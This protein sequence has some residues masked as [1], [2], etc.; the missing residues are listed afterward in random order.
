[1]TPL[2]QNKAVEAGWPEEVAARLSAVKSP[3]GIG[4][5]FD[6][7][8]QVASDLEFGSPTSGPHSVLTSLHTPE[9]KK[10]VEEISRNS[11]DEIL[12]RLRGLFS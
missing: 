7:D 9:M 8:P 11:M 6:G 3:A 2:I 12:D 4:F 10:Q 1:M 5:H